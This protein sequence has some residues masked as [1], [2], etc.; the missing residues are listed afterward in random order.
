M[1]L[2]YME[3]VD[4]KYDVKR[5]A[6]IPRSYD[7]PA[8]EREAIDAYAANL[9]DVIN[10]QASRNISFWAEGYPFL[11][12]EV[13]PR[14]DHPVGLC[15]WAIPGMPDITDRDFVKKFK[16]LEQTNPILRDPRVHTGLLGTWN[17]YHIN[18]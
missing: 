12:Q 13:L 16:E 4:E 14:L 15:T 17:P 10:R 1:A 18:V 2:S 11:V 5:R 9:A 7:P 6:V 8:E 3:Q